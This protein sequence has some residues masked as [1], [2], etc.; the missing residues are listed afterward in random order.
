MKKRL[1][2]LEWR[3]CE[4]RAWLGWMVFWMIISFMLLSAM[5]MTGH[6]LNKVVLPPVWLFIWCSPWLCFLL[7]VRVTEL[8]KGLVNTLQLG[9]LPV[10]RWSRPVVPGIWS[11]DRMNGRYRLNRI[12]TDGLTVHYPWRLYYQPLFLSPDNQISDINGREHERK[13]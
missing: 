8:D 6:L 10:W 4:T 1:Y 5:L 2:L 3:L 13:V 9:G 12:G 7:K 11:V